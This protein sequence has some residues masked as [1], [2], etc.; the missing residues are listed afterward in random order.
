MTTA[1]PSPVP[2]T[3]PF[4]VPLL[5]VNPE[6]GPLDAPDDTLDPNRRL[7]SQSLTQPLPDITADRPQLEDH[8]QSENLALPLKSRKGL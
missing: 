5:T 6:I 7:V 3:V 1:T 8:D 4:P 2:D